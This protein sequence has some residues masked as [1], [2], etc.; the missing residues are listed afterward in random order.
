MKRKCK[1]KGCDK[2]HNAKGFCA[3]HYSRWRYHNI[4]SVREKHINHSY[5]IWQKSKLTKEEK[6]LS[7][8]ATRKDMR[9]LNKRVRDQREDT[10]RRVIGHDKIESNNWDTW[11]RGIFLKVIDELNWL[12]DKEAMVCGGALLEKRL[13]ELK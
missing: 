4:P 1:I 5:K 3:K 7:E 2:P 10:L 11:N 8:K 12:K 6:M 13:E 9:E